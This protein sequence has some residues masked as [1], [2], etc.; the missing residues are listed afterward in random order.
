MSDICSQKTS[1]SDRGSVLLGIHSVSPFR[2]EVRSRFPK[3]THEV[4]SVRC[5]RCFPRKQRWQAALDRPAQIALFDVAVRRKK[6]LAGDHSVFH[7]NLS[8]STSGDGILM[9]HHDNRSPLA[10]QAR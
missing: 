6:P 2:Q 7:H 1:K 3:E 4:C 9:S 5:S 8:S 10:I